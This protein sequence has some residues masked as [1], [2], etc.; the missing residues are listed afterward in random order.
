[1]VGIKPITIQASKRTFKER[2]DQII[3]P[4]HIF[5]Q[6]QE[7]IIIPRDPNRIPGYKHPPPPP[8]PFKIPKRKIARKSRPIMGGLDVYVRKAK[9]W[10]KVSRQPL[11][12]QEAL[13]LGGFITEKTPRAS[14]K[15]VP[16]GRPAST[17]KFPFAFKP[18]RFRAPKGKSKLKGIGE[19][20][21]EKTKYRIDA[22]KELKGITFKG[23]KAPRTKKKKKKGM[24][25]WNI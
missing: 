21:I 25:W 14:F 17:F 15:L 23:I 12:R 22:P 13:K 5:K 7:Q 2:Q 24:W 10:V 19:V 11:A 6:R 4:K 8:P 20:F 3:I 18:S 9:R 1:M 16:A